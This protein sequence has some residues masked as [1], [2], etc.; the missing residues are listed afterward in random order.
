MI[1]YT[2]YNKILD[3][4]VSDFN[5]LKIRTSVPLPTE[6]DYKVGYIQRYFI[7]KRNDEGSYIYEVTKEYY[8]DIIRNPFF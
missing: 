8:N 5:V 2:R 3:E 4:D 6:N 1:N 7:Q